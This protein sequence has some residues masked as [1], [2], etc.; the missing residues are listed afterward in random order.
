MPHSVE[1]RHRID[2]DRAAGTSACGRVA[3]FATVDTLRPASRGPADS[4][5]CP[6]LTSTEPIRPL[7]T[8]SLYLSIAVR[9]SRSARRSSASRWRWTVTFA[10]GITADARISRIVVTTSSSMKVKPFAKRALQRRRPAHSVLDSHGDRA[11]H[12]VCSI[13][14]S[15][16]PA[17]NCSV[18][19]RALGRARHAADLDR[20]SPPGRRRRTASAASSPAPD[21][22]A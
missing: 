3:S 14:P 12:S 18:I 2:R 10:S 22:P 15:P 17:L 7:S 1:L 19:A 21:A 13:A 11:C 6:A 20:S 4:L 8:A 16:S 9:I 5:R